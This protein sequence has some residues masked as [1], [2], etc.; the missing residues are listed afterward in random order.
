MDIHAFHHGQKGDSAQARAA[1]SWLAPDVWKHPCELQVRS[2]QMA[3]LLAH[4]VTL[5]SGESVPRS[6]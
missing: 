1:F 5:W 6:F 3:L 2:W 4:Y